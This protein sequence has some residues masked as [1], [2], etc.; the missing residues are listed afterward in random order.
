MLE[1]GEDIGNVEMGIAFCLV[2]HGL[3]MAFQASRD[4][5]IE[6]EVQAVFVTEATVQVGDE[7]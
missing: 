4:N 6:N 5:K 3:K 2:P 7:L 1:G